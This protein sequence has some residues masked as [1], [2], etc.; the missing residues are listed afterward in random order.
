NKY[1][2]DTQDVKYKADNKSSN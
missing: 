1:G 2:K